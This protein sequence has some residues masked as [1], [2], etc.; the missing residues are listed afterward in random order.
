VDNAGPGTASSLYAPADS[1]T[2]AV[3]TGIP[4]V[5]LFQSLFFEQARALVQFCQVQFGYKP[6]RHTGLC[7]VDK[8]ISLACKLIVRLDTTI[9]RGPHKQINE[10]LA[11]L[12]NQCR[13][14]TVIEIV[15]P[16]TDQSKSLLGE[17]FRR[18]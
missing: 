16:A 6:I 8:V 3:S 4:A 9:V 13:D 17:I 14:R 18:R 2:G 5:S 7:P 1:C 12:I 11:A 10:V 15:E